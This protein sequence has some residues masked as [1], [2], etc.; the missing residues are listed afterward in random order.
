MTLKEILQRLPTALVQG[1][2]DNTCQLEIE[3]RSNCIFINYQKSIQ[4]YN[5]FNKVVIQ[6]RYFIYQFWIKQ[7]ICSSYIIAQ[8]LR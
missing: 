3:N 5:E 2:A 4:Q 1:K 8:S 7:N 6:N